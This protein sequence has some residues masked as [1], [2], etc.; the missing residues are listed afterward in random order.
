MKHLTGYLLAGAAAVAV[1]GPVA[2]SAHYTGP[3]AVA[4]HQT[5][6]A[7]LADGRDDQPVVL[8]GRLV[9]Q[10]TS[11]KYLFADKTGEI[12]VEIDRHLFAPQPVSETTVIEL[13]GEVEKEY[14]QSPE[15]DVDS[16]MVL[17]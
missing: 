10:L 11:D 7:V 8:Q 9:K 2:A 1:L 4:A 12:R 13:R 16:L 14:L 5:V 17:P 15:I 6:A 3:G